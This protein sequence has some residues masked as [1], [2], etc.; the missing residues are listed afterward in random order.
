MEKLFSFLMKLFTE[1]FFGSVTIKFEH[2]K[3]THIEITT[4]RL[5]KYGDLPED[6]NRPVR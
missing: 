6:S 1:K 2:G 3:V 5:L 4:R